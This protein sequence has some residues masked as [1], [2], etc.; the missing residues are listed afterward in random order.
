MAIAVQTKVVFITLGYAYFHHP[1][2]GFADY[3]Y[4]WR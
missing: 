2:I 3:R 1:E 4:H